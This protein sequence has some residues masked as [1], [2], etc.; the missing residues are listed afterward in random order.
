MIFLALKIEVG[1]IIGKISFYC[2]LL[3]ISRK[4]FYKY[5]I[6]KDRP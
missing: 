4:D 3:G 5:L 6:N 1:R 2:P